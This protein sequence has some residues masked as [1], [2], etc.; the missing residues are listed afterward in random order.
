M[1]EWVVGT[2]IGDYIGA[3]TGIHSPISYYEPDNQM[4]RPANTAEQ[5]GTH[6]KGLG[7]FIDA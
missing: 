1:G 7:P 4:M 5:D 3:T 2:I 6:A